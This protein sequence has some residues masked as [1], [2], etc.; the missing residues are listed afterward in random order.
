MAA[1]KTVIWEGELDSWPNATVPA[2]SWPGATNAFSTTFDGR[3]DAV[4]QSGSDARRP[5]GDDRRAGVSASE[6]RLDID[7]VPLPDIDKIWPRATAVAN[8]C[9]A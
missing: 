1:W 5:G 7:P 3:A 2:S 4:I 9:R 8:R 6:I